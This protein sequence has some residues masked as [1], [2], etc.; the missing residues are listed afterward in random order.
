MRSFPRRRR[1][2]STACAPCP[3][4]GWKVRAYLDIETDWSQAITVVG[5]HRPDR[6]TRQWTR[7]NL[8]VPELREFLSGGDAS[9]TYN[10]A[11]FDLPLIHERM[12]VDLASE[13]HHRDLMY[14]CW[15][16]NLYGGLKKVERILGIHRDSEGVDGLMAI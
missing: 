3:L 14:D 4:N 2:S 10:A 13:F 8:S 15:S 11:K 5:V 6:G 12:Y 1:T 7:P 9:C 16:Q